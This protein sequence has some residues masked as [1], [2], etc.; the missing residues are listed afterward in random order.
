MSYK[1]MTNDDIEQVELSCNQHKAINCLLNNASV[2]GAARCCGLTSRTLFRYLRDPLFSAELQRRRSALLD[3]TSTGL[4]S[5][6]QR[7]LET[8]AG[9]LDDAE[10]TDALKLRAALATLKLLYDHVELSELAA[11]VAALEKGGL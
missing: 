5:L 7:S 3:A 11:R 2:E 4:V 9:I 10:A 8:L 6:S 1:T